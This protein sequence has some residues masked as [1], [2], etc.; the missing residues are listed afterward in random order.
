MYALIRVM[1]S[2]LALIIG[3]STG[4]IGLLALVW[5]SWLFLARMQMLAPYLA[6]PPP[7]LPLAV[8]GGFL[9]ALLTAFSLLVYLLLPARAV[10]GLFVSRKDA[11]RVPPTAP[12]SLECGELAKR[13]GLRPP[14]LYVYPSSAANAWA[15]STL[16]GSVVAVSVPLANTLSAAERQWVLAHELAHIRYFD[17]GAAA[18]WVSANQA[19]RVGWN[20]HRGLLNLTT[21]A[22]GSLG[23]PLAVW[24]VPCAPLFIVSYTLIA[25]DTVARCTFRLVDRW[26]GRAMEYR[27]DRVA[28]RLVG[29]AAGIDAL[30][31]LAAGIEP[32]FS[33][34]ATHPATP[35]RLK[36]LQRMLR[37]KQAAAA[38]RMPGAAAAARRVASQTPAAQAAATPSAPRGGGIAQPAAAVLGEAETEPAGA[39]DTGTPGVRAR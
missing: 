1:A 3:W 13:L 24:A 21:R 4:F 12:M 8:A 11:A 35:R 7:F 18:F 27:A 2:L 37:A 23:L 34:F 17:S 9:A 25:A 6:L 5:G 39:S 10:M 16:F 19:V 29:P 15:L 32:S 30:T 33:L 26:I 14:A 28:S 31:R 38:P 20:I 36:R 22:L